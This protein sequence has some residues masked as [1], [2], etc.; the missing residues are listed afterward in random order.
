MGLGFEEVFPLEGFDKRNGPE[1]VVPVGGS[2]F[3]RYS[4]AIGSPT[5]QSS[6]T[7]RVTVR[8]IKTASVGSITTQLLELTGAGEGEA[9]IQAY[10]TGRA[11][12][13]L[14]V[15]VL[16][17]RTLSVTYYLVSDTGKH[18]TS[19]TAAELI[20][21]AGILNSIYLPQA[22][23][24]FTSL[25]TVPVKITRN[26]GGAVSYGKVS[27]NTHPCDELE[28]GGEFLSDLIPFAKTGDLHIF[29]AWETDPFGDGRGPLEGYTPK[30]GRYCL[31]RDN[32]GSA[33]LWLVAA[34]EIGHALGVSHT[35]KTRSAT[36]RLFCKVMPSGEC[37][38]GHQ[39]DCPHWAELSKYLM[40]AGNNTTNSLIPPREAARMNSFLYGK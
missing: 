16:P 17:K 2:R 23:I 38:G 6:N 8:S 31:I 36:N 3:V 39:P 21:L 35:S 34:H 7:S 1:Q 18:A 14:R 22:N 11:T 15:Y 24:E 4:S 29:F 19:R 37:E 25:G 10:G 5:I 33:P 40:M 30:S 13:R 9:E 26:L 27:E 28:A 12:E 32:T 20:P